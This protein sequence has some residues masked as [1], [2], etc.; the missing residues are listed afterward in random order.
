VQGE[1]ECP[2]ETSTLVNTSVEQLVTHVLRWAVIV[3]YSVNTTPKNT[4]TITA[5]MATK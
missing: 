3:S 2:K 1:G 5:K 4:T